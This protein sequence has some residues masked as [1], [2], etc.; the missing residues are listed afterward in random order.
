M[1]SATTTQSGYAA[2]PVLADVLPPAKQRGRVM[3][4][5]HRNPTIVARRRAAAR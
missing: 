4:F 5:V 3:T 2:A 1:S